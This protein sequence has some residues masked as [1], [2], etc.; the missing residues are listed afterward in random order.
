M[1][2]TILAIDV[3]RTIRDMLHLALT[4]AGFE[5]LSKLRHLRSVQILP[6]DCTSG[7][8]RFGDEGL[9]HLANLPHLFCSPAPRTTKRD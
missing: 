6:G 3:S 9:R 2:L 8:L 1:S 4:D 7:P 5:A